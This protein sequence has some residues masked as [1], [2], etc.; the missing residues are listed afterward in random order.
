MALA[1]WTMADIVDTI[2]EID[3]DDN[4]KLTD[5]E[6]DFCDDV[7]L[8]PKKHNFDIDLSTKQ[9]EVCVNIIQKYRG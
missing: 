4:T 1:S 3:A 5:W 8:L 7:I 6:V 9:R 2:I